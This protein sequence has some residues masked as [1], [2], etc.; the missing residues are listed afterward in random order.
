MPS[1]KRMVLSSDRTMC[2]FN[3]DD[4]YCD[5]YRSSSRCCMSLRCNI[6]S[7]VRM[8]L[9]V[10]LSETS[11]NSDNENEGINGR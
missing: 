7:I 2:S 11:S 6:I 3:D 4:M 9:P 1:M 10:Y 8:N 5:E